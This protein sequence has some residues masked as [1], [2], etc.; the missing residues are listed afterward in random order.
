MNMYEHS[1]LA[2][3]F[4][5]LCFFEIGVN[6]STFPLFYIFREL[7]VYNGG[8]STNINGRLLHNYVT[9]KHSIDSVICLAAVHVMWETQRSSSAS[10]PKLETRH[11]AQPAWAV[12]I[13]KIV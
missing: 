6:L 5:S 10:C 11:F 3:F 9:N 12:S 2:S 7:V 13:K 4:D 8:P 1:F